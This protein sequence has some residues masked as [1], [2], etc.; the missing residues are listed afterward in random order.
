MNL[1]DRIVADLSTA[2]KQKEASVV[3]TLR[4]LRAAIKNVEIDKQRS[5]AEEEILAVLR[6]SL[7]Q[8]TDAKEQ[9]T[10]GGRADLVQKTDAEMVI[11]NA[12]LPPEM[13]DSDL[14]AAVRA[15]VADVGATSAKDFGKV[16]GAVVAKVG[17]SASGGRVSVVVKT[18]LASL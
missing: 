12:Y 5:L 10:Q 7:K 16:M 13:S 9:F 18:V 15:V 8:L 6:T 17:G 14:D 11:L 3:G 2:M 4:M 1:A